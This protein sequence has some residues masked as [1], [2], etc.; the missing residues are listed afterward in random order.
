MRRSQSASSVKV[1]TPQEQQQVAQQNQHAHRHERR[2]RVIVRTDHTHSL[3]GP[4]AHAIGKTPL[5][6]C[7]SP[8][9]EFESCPVKV[10]D[11]QE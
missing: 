3:C 6:F 8:A 1:L 2:P 5:E 7:S 10:L 9:P 4:T 11:V